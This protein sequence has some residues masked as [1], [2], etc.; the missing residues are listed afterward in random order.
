MKRYKGE[1]CYTHLHLCGGSTV[2]L[3]IGLGNPGKHYEHT[4]HNAGFWVIDNLVHKLDITPNCGKFQSIVAEGHW[5]GEKIILLKP[6]TY[7]NLSG[8]AV[9]AAVKYWQINLRDLLII[10]DDI[11]LP[12]KAVRFRSKGTSGGHKGVSNIIELLGTDNF[13]R[14]KV[15]IGPV[16]EY[17]NAADYVLARIPKSDIELY[18][19]I[20]N[21]CAD[22]VQLWITSGIDQVMNQYNGI[23][24]DLC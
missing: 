20:T 1:E 18:H 17:L 6:Q 7:M 11:D 13:A 4:R 22:A 14:L 10:Y 2:K 24:I 19:K 9:Y 3:I 5:N 16:P 23:E 15:G 12:V 8:Q 21:I